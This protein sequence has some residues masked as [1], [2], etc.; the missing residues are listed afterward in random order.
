MGNAGGVTMEHAAIPLSPKGLLQAAHLAKSFHVV[1]ARILVSKFIRTQATAG[2][3]CAQT[4]VDPEVHPLLHEFSSL[5]ETLIAGMNGAQ[6]RPVADA[7]WQVADP[8]ARMGAAA[9]TFTEFAARVDT[10][11]SEL[12]SLPDRTVIFGHGM[13]FGMLCWRLGGNQVRNSRDMKAFH[14]FRQDM[15][16]GNCAIY[17]LT[18]SGGDRWTWSLV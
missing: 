2:P 12:P 14:S 18:A 8:N 13:W 17:L 10:F 16:I 7:Y 15:A 5:D 11:S 9:E 3:F 1:P 4:G 6:R